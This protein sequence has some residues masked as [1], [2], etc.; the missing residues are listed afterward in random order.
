MR[1]FHIASYLLLSYIILPSFL[2]SCSVRYK[3]YSSSQAIVYSFLPYSFFP[4]INLSFLFLFPH[5]FSPFCSCLVSS[6]V[7]FSF[8]SF[9][10]SSTRL[11]FIHSFISSFFYACCLPFFPI[12][13]AFINLQRTSISFAFSSLAKFS[14]VHCKVDNIMIIFIILFQNVLRITN[15]HYLI[16]MIVISRRVP[17]QVLTVGNHLHNGHTS[18]SSSLSQTTRLDLDQLHCKINTT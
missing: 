7:Y 10:L 3:G 11:P 17:S 13:S 9:R 1:S 2:S 12:S 14:V 4:F 5:S 8:F 16:I 15:R 6:F 18:Q